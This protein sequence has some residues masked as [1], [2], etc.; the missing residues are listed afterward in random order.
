VLAPH[1]QTLQGAANPSWPHLEHG[2]VVRV[3]GPHQQAL[4]CLQLLH[5]VIGAEVHVA[6]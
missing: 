4:A 2:R 3:R 6:V 1:T 5:L